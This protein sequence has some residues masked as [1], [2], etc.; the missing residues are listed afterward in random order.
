MTHSCTMQS[1]EKN[2]DAVIYTKEHRSRHCAVRMVGR[3]GYQLAESHRRCALRDVVRHCSSAAPLTHRR[4]TRKPVVRRIR[5]ESALQKDSRVD[6]LMALLSD[7]AYLSQSNHRRS[8][9]PMDYRWLAGMKPKWYANVKKRRSVPNQQDTV[10][11]DNKTSVQNITGMS[12]CKIVS[13]TEVDHRNISQSLL[14]LL[15]TDSHQPAGVEARHYSNEKYTHTQSVAASFDNSREIFTADGSYVIVNDSS[16]PNVF[17]LAPLVP[18]STTQCS[19][20]DRR[21]GA[22]KQRLH[23]RTVSSIRHC[24]VDKTNRRSEVGS[25]VHSGAHDVMY[26][27]AICCLSRCDCFCFFDSSSAEHTG[28]TVPTNTMSVDGLVTYAGYVSC[29]GSHRVTCDLHLVGALET[30]SDNT[31]PA[32]CGNGQLASAADSYEHE[33]FVD[34]ICVDCGCELTGDDMLECAYSVPIC[35][36]CSLVANHD[37]P[38]VESSVMSDH[39]YACVA[40]DRLAYLSPLKE[41]PSSSYAI[42]VYQQPGAPDVDVVDDITFLSFPSK[43]LMHRYILTQCSH[44]DPAVKSSWMELARCERTWHA[45]HKSHRRS[46]FGSARNRHMDRFSA[47]NRLHEQIRL[48][49]VR[50]VSAQNSADLLGIKLKTS[51]SQNSAGKTV[52]GRKCKNRHVLNDLQTQRPTRMAAKGQYYCLTRFR[53]KGSALKALLEAEHVDIMKL[54]QQQAEEAL[55]LLHI[56]SVI[57]RNNCSQPGI[58][59]STFVVCLLMSWMC[60]YILQNAQGW[61]IVTLEH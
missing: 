17:L 54:T 39:G 18:V 59:N 46:W 49:L 40:A 55:K 21:T 37:I 30:V 5:P 61:D 34:N 6:G 13:N 52:V 26:S 7:H 51:L 22:I 29:R 50:P 58:V 36:I 44:C 12:S 11:F 1:T 56:P 9:L 27:G 45:G 2:S 15:T 47:H 24:D 8:S 33:D 4:V 16:D 57:T 42:P 38:S 41:T 23:K 43:V 31:E 35:A 25:L 28:D 19:E 32:A 48:G 53:P 3:A 20:S 10:K 60:C 14:A